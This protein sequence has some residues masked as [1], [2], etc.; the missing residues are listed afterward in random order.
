MTLVNMHKLEESNTWSKGGYDPQ[1]N[2]MNQDMY[3]PHG[4]KACNREML[5]LSKKSSVLAGLGIFKGI[6]E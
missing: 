1:T 3:F 6:W 2:E 5:S 4:Q